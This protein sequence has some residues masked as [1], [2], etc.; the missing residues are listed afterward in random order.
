LGELGYHSAVAEGS[1]LLGGE[2]VSLGEQFWTFW[3]LVVL[4]SWRVKQSP[5]T[6]YYIPLECLESVTQQ[7]IVISQKICIMTEVFVMI[8]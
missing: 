8:H 1:D 2:P 6:V 5:L 4:S 7:C 3:R